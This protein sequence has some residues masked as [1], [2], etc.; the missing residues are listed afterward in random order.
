M[1]KLFTYLLFLPLMAQA[2]WD[3][4]NTNSIWLKEDADGYGGDIGISDSAYFGYTGTGWSTILDSVGR[5]TKY[6]GDAITEGYILMGNADGRLELTEPGFGLGSVTSVGLAAGTSG[7]D[8]NIT[9]SPVTTAGTITINIPDAGP[10]A[11]GLVTTGSQTFAGAKTFS[12]LAAFQ[13]GINVTN[14]INHDGTFTFGWTEG[15]ETVI[16]TT[17]QIIKY[18]GIDVVT[19]DMFK[20]GAGAYEV[21]SIGTPDQL[22]RVNA[23]GT[24]FEWYTPTFLAAEVDG[25]VTNEGSLTVNAGTGTTS[26]I[27]SNTSGSTDVTLT[28]AGINTIGEVGNVITITATEVDGSTTNEVQNLSYDA[29]NREVDISL[30]GTSATIPLAVDDGATEGLSSYTPADFTV[31]AGNVAI[32]YTNGQEATTSQDGFLSQ[33][34]W[35][36][37]NNKTGLVQTPTEQTGQTASIGATTAYTTP[38]AD[39]YY[40]ISVCATI[41]TAAGT[42]LDLASVVKWTEATDNVVKTWPSNNINNLNRTVTNGTGVAIAFDVVAHVKAETAIQ[43]QTVFSFVGGAPQYNIHIYIE[44]L[45]F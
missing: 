14:S 21:L 24:N 3:A 41:T 34:D 31:T 10:T 22:L 26:L 35:D 12:S 43:Y 15:S 37:F 20:G 45:A 17:G 19:G 40:R 33:T 32:D 30:G 18:Y 13:N 1:K 42:S 25:S 39:G 9:G 28:A 44:K 36:T 2:Q 8:V 6:A 23:G 29:G 5:F 11:R 4:W 7:T 16:N 38:A 27:S